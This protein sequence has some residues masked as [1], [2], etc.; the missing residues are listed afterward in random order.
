MQH[1]ENQTR[2]YIFVRISQVQEKASVGEKVEFEVSFDNP[3][4]VPLTNC[5]VSMESSGFNNIEDQAVR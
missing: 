5:N 4:P 1:W 3:L 2:N